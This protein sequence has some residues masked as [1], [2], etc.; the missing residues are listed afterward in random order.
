MLLGRLEKHP[1]IESRLAEN[2]QK[3]LDRIRASGVHLG[4]A[5]ARP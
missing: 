2:F 5:K 4:K 1:E 3:M